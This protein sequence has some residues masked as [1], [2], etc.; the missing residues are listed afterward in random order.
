[1]SVLNTYGICNSD[2]AYAN[3]DSILDPALQTQNISNMM[4]P[5]FDILSLSIAYS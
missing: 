4:Q 1:M 5:D 2:N 3:P